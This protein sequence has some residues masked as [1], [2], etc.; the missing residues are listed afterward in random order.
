VTFTHEFLFRFVTII[1]FSR[2]PAKK[3]K[4]K[5]QQQQ[6][7]IMQ[8]NMI[9]MNENCLTIVSCELHILCVSYYYKTKS[10]IYL[11]IKEIF[12]QCLE[13]L[14]VG[15]AIWTWRMFAR[16]LFN[17]YRLVFRFQ[18]L[19][20]TSDDDNNMR[21][22]T[23]KNEWMKSME[24]CNH[25]LCHT[26]NYYCRCRS[27]H[28]NVVCCWHSYYDYEREWNRKLY[29]IYADLCVHDC[30]DVVTSHEELKNLLSN[31][32][33]SSSLLVTALCVHKWS[34]CWNNKTQI[35]TKNEC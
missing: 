35:G 23:V 1:I 33:P 32:K 18:V 7:G 30:N 29:E 34:N 17:T 6:C 2:F 14:K 4:L 20:M 28:F 25:Y 31:L 3:A 19:T 9:R 24:N 26:N 21:R 15:K 22:K 8:R 13:P 11:R 10:T 16:S 5:K 27:C 12:S